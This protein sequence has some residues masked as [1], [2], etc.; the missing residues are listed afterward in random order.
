MNEDLD[1]IGLHQVFGDFMELLDGERL[2]H[3]TGYIRSSAM[4]QVMCSSSKPA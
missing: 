1:A 2:F 4:E 3:V